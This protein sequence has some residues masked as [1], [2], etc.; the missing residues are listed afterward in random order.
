MDRDGDSISLTIHNVTKADQG[1]YICEAVNYV[2]EARSVALVVVVSQEVRFMPAPPAVTHQH[3]MEFDVEED[4]SSRSP[5]P[6]EIL[7]E[8]ELD[9]NEICK[10]SPQDSGVYTCRAIN[11]VGETLCRASLVVINAKAF[12]GKTRGRELTAVSLGS[13]K[14]HINFD[15]FTP[16]KCV[17]P[18]TNVTAAVG[19]PVILQCLV[20]GK[21]NPTAEWYKDGD[22]VT[23]SRCIIQ[24]KTAGHFNLLITNVTESDAG[25]YKCIIENTAGC[26][27]TTALLK[28]NINKQTKKEIKQ[29]FTRFTVKVSGFPKPTVQWS[30]NGKVIKSSSIYKLIEEREEYTLVITRVTTEYEGE[31][32][33]TATNRFGQTTCTTYLEVKKPDIQP[34][35]CSEGGEVHF[36]YKIED[37]PSV[38]FKW[39][40]SGIEIRQ[41]EKYRILSRYTSSSLELLN[42]VK[43]DSGE[44]TCKASNQHGTDSCTASLIVTGKTPVGPFL[45]VHPMTLYVGK[46]AVFQ[47][48]LT[49]SS[50]MEVVWHKDNIAI[51]SEGNYVMK[52]EKNKYSLHIKSLELTDQ[53]VYLC[54]ASNSVGTA[55]FTTELKVINKPSFV[56]TIEPASAAVNDPL[57]LECQVDEDTGVTIT[58]TRDGKKVHQSMECKLSFEDKVAVLEI[59][60]SKL[61][62]SGKYVCTATNEAGSS[63]CEAVVTVQGKILKMIF[64]LPLMKT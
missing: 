5:S 29:Q 46:Q 40:K 60:K 56:K 30:H 58:W 11:V 52:C 41:S 21:P 45:N 62:D 26:I 25:E 17:I 35:R 20:S 64:P 50:P 16:P 53:G 44:Y 10:V 7:L 4:D 34:V 19:T 43:A 24:E 9:E 59:P 32:S 61:K 12:S 37:A 57:R 31:Y 48:S 23:D 18:L 15:V 2:G 14:V 33:C 54:K 36:N 47:C 55:T 39:Y 1:E 13:A 49:G 22:R 27:E 8:V 42:P 3:V 63:S 28:V 51:S 38:T 6:Q